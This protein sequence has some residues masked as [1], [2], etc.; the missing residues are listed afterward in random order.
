M[1]N[2]IVER[3][4]PTPNVVITCNDSTFISLAG[5]TLTP[6]F[7][8]MRGLMKIKGPLKEALKVKTLLDL[9]YKLRT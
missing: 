2:G 4:G 5:K 8:F 9:A 7:A 1:K 3:S 6:E